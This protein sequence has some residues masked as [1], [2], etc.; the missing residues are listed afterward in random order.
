VALTVQQDKLLHATENESFYASIIEIKVGEDTTQQAIVRDM[1]RHP[2]KP[3]IM[4]IDFM[5]VSEGELL[6]IA[7]P[8]HFAGE[9]ESPAGKTSGV[10][11][12]HHITDIEI[13]ALPKDLPEFLTADLSDMDVGDSVML[14]YI[15]LPEGVTIPALDVGEEQ[16]AVVANAIH[17]KESQGGD[18]EVE[19]IPVEGEEGLEDGEE[20]TAEGE[21][22]DGSPDGEK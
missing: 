17:V 11:I 9:E 8:I 7:V 16:D 20:G 3:V 19:E 1:H 21:S 14:S 6:T 12:Q 5:R 10:V 22:D 18:V 13:E 4:H 2:Y 15:K